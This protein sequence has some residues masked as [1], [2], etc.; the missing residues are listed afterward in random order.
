MTA[1]LLLQ[2]TL[3]LLHVGLFKLG[4]QHSQPGRLHKQRLQ[5]LLRLHRRLH[6]RCCGCL[7]PAWGAGQ[8]VQ[9]VMGRR[10]L[11][12]RPQGLSAISIQ[13]LCLSCAVAGK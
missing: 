5:L 1:P 2:E 8:F 7:V 3:E 11:G 4:A 6:G 10:V 9:S 12:W 13:R